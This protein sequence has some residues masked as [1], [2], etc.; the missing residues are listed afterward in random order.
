MQGIRNLL[1]VIT[2]FTMG[3]SITLSLAALEIMS[4]ND[5]LVESII[6]F[7]IMFI[8]A[9]YLIQKTNKYLTANIFFTILITSLLILNIF[10]SYNLPT[11]LLLGLLIF[12]VGY[13]LLHKSVNRKNSLLI[14][15]T[16]LFGMIHGLG[17]GSYLVS[18]GISSNNIITALLGFNLGVEIGQIICISAS[19]T[20]IGILIKLKFNKIVEIIKNVSFMFVTSMGFFWFIQRL[21][22]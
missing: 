9:E 8:G 22:N 12:S 6:G 4:P 17:F 7:T 19:L 1:I 16:V 20:I 3:H 5:V 21:I 10:T 15:I 14:I 2:G 11:I 18:S 13:F